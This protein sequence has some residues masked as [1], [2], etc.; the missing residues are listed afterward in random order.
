MLFSLS[1]YEE[2]KTAPDT[3]HG[4]TSQQHTPKL[5]NQQQLTTHV[6]LHHHVYDQFCT[7]CSSC[8]AQGET[9]DSLKLQLD[10]SADQYRSLP[11]VVEKCT[12][13]QILWDIFLSTKTFV[14]YIQ[15]PQNSIFLTQH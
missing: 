14:F 11:M 2:S 10:T 7:K 1:F 3:T 4:H 8:C 5:L 13:E 6:L 15:F 12:S 9:G